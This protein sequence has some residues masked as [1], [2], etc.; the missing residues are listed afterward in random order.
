[1]AISSVSMLVVWNSPMPDTGGGVFDLTKRIREAHDAEGV[2]TEDVED[3][4]GRS[5]IASARQFMATR[6]R[7]AARGRRGSITKL[8]GAALAVVTER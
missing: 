8:G 4:H 7:P 5:F 3:R 6:D 2:L 1:M